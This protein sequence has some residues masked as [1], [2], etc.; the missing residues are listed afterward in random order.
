MKRLAASFHERLVTAALIGLSALLPLV[1]VLAH[2]GVAPILLAMGL[3]VATRAEPWR[4]GVPYFVLRPQWSAPFVRAALFFLAFCVWIVF[5][6]LWSP[7]SGAS[8][9]V[10]D[11][12]G[13]ALAGGAV[14]WEISR[15]PPEATR[16]LSTCLAWCGAAVIVLIAFEAATSGFLR[17]ITPPEDMTPGRVRDAISVGRGATIVTLTFFGIAVLL[18]E[19]FRSIAFV[20]ALYAATLFATWKLDI[21]SNFAGAL[22]GGGVFIAALKWPRVTLMSVGG[23]FL[24]A[25]ALV[26]LAVFIPADAAIA[27][28]SGHLPVS[29]LQRLAIWQSAARDAINCLPFGC[30]ADYSRVIAATSEKV[31]I[32]GAPKPL[33]V[34]PLHP[35]NLFLQIW[36]EFGLPGVLLF[37]A[38]FFNGALA[39]RSAPLST[40]EKAAIAASVACLLVSALVE[41]SLWQVWR[42][43]API[44]AGVFIAAARQAR[45]AREA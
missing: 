42:V 30:G 21:T 44:F 25:L 29:W 23:A 27:Q 26:P 24:V 40:L 19:R 2:R 12:L 43:A 35:H 45:L 39:L 8:R 32:P 16:G 1:V 4:L 9:L 7:R 14:I 13:P 5:S 15:R 6:G 17:S 31:I 33:N 10:F 28:L 41:A 36:I 18:Y 38:S 20:G 22:L 11:V 34:M 3:I 37:G